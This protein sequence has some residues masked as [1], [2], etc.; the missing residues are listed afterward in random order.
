MELIAVERWL[1]DTLTGDAALAAAAKNGIHPDVDR[2][3]NPDAIAVIFSLQS[4]G[5]DDN[6]L[7]A[8]RT[9]STPLYLVRARKRTR[10]AAE[11]ETSAKRIDALLHG[12]EDAIGEAPDTYRLYVE[13]ESPFR[14]SF[15]ENGVEYHQ[16]GGLYRFRVIPAE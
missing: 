16:L 1:F 7:C 10:R 3:T 5:A 4:P 9:E 11:L 14:F 8:T 12:A 15:S 6:S 13:R 2:G